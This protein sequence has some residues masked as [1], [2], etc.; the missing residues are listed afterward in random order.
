MRKSRKL[1]AILAVLALLV[2]MLPVGTAFAASGYT[3]LQVPN[4][5]DDDWYKLGTVLV[6]VSAGALGVGDSVTFRLPEDFKLADDEDNLKVDKTGKIIYDGAVGASKPSVTFDAPSTYA[7]DKN[8]LTNSDYSIDIL[9]NNE[10]KVSVSSVTYSGEKAFIMIAFPRVYVADGFSGDIELIADAPSGSGFPTGKVVIARVPGGKVE[11][12]AIDVKSFSDEIAVKIRAKETTTGSLEEDSKSLKFKLPSGFEWAKV[13]FTG[14]GYTKINDWLGY[15]VIWGDSTNLKFGTGKVDK[16]TMEIEVTG[17]SKDSPAFVEFLA[18]I[19]VSDESKAKVGDVA[20][21][22]S[23]ESDV[24]VSELV[25]AKYGEHGTTVSAKDAPVVYAGK[26]EQKIG[27]IVIKENVVGSLIKDRTIILTLP[28]NA[29][30]GKVDKDASNNSAKIEFVGFPGSDGKTIK[31]KVTDPSSKNPAELVLKD[32]EVCLEPGVTGD[33]EIEV[34]GTAGVSGKITVA[35]IE[36]PVQVTASAKPEVKIGAAGQP[37][38]DII[39]TEVKAGAINDDKD[40]YILLD[41]PDGVKF[42]GTPKVEVTEGD[43]DIDEAGVKLQNNDNELYIPVKSSSTKASTIKVSGIKYTVDRTVAEGDIKVKV[44]G[45]ALVDVNDDNSMNDYWG[46]NYTVDSKVEIEGYEYDINKDGL[47]PQTSTAASTFNAVVVTPAPGEQK[48]TVVFKVGDTKFTLNGVEQTMDV[49]PYVKNGR[50]YVPVRY[51]AQAV[52][53]AAENILYS[54]GKVTL[55]KGDKVVQFTIGSN[56]MLINGV[57]VTMDVKAEITN[58]RT[59]L[60][61]R[62]VAQA[63]G[64]QVNWDPTEQTVTMTL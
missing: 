24:D 8:A 64:A 13:D 49:A 6:E 34:S 52:G 50:T 33:L 54:G 37:A 60:P 27:D 36:L 39:I 56:V 5:S 55:I 15:K 46:T 44:K 29:K 31:Y 59:M 32:M 19:Q 57:A 21:S 35:K 11:L 61:F 2:T 26:L 20:I 25:I 23:G 42:S 30:W 41:L 18:K 1:I 47:F 63:L 22:V 28:S 14:T 48:A 51:S 62:Y 9:D 43:L 58:G 12:S 3:A 7:G 45:T 16:E 10:F 53:V 40:D 38:G 4:V 17:E